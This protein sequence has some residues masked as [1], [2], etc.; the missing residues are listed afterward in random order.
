MAAPHGALHEAGESVCIGHLCT[1]DV[2]EAHHIWAA[3]HRAGSRQAAEPGWEGGEGRTII[4]ILHAAAAPVAVCRASKRRRCCWSSPPPGR[5]S[6]SG[7][8]ASG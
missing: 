1:R 6:W 4:D 3:R 7:W 5:S 8:R 2:S